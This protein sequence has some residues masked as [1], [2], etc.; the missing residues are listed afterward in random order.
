MDYLDY[1]NHVA[2]YLDNEK[3]EEIFRIATI[4]TD[5]HIR[6]CYDLY[7]EG[8]DLVERIPAAKEA[9]KYMEEEL[10][11]TNSVYNQSPW[12][13]CQLD[14]LIEGSGAYE[15]KPLYIAYFQRNKKYTIEK[16]PSKYCFWVDGNDWYVCKADRWDINKF[17][18]HMDAENY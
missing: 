14:W 17:K 9:I 15:Y 12:N 2:D 18:K 8:I 1:I 6:L 16:L 11:I 4:P 7:E 5:F 10:D 13:G 3:F